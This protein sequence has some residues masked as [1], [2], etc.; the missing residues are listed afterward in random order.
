MNG[1][2][3]NGTVPS[4]TVLCNEFHW[5]IVNY[6]DIS[7]Y[8]WWHDFSWSCSQ[9]AESEP[10]LNH[11]TLLKCAKQDW[12][13]GVGES[14]SP[15][16]EHV[17]RSC[18]RSVPPAWAIYNRISQNIRNE[19]ESLAVLFTCCWLIEATGKEMSCSR[20]QQCSIMTVCDRKTDIETAQYIESYGKATVR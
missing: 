10:F 8:N 20:T 16:T 9:R 18:V 11:Y 12:M 19:K 2:F 5:R 13:C 17:G 6:T 14:K 1:T 7:K 4:R 15:S 3:I